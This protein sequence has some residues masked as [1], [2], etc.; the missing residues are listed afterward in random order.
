MA[1]PIDLLDSAYLLL[2][3]K[4]ALWALLFALF[5]YVEFGILFVICSFFYALHVGTSVADR[6]RGAPS[7]YSVFNKDCRS[8]EGALTSEQL[9]RE[10]TRRL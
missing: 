5:V 10:I 4:V 3:L 1:A 2:G 8:I 9:E 6:K 7:A